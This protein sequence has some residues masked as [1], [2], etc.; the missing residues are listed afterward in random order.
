[1]SGGDTE[2]R[3]YIADTDEPGWYRLMWE[4]DPCW[5]GKR[6]HY[7]LVHESPVES[8]QPACLAVPHNCWPEPD[9][10]PNSEPD[11][12]SRAQRRSGDA[13]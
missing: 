3:I 10:D 7:F 5:C 11:A 9:L 1:M 2:I 12:A 8:N 4:K 13:P 6:V